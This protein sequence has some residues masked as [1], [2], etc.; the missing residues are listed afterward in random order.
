MVLHVSKWITKDL[1]IE[2]H[3]WLHVWLHSSLHHITWQGSGA[4]AAAACCGLSVLTAR[5]THKCAARV[6]LLDNGSGDRPQG[7]LTFCPLP[8]AGRILS[9][10]S[11]TPRYG[12]YEQCESPHLIY[13]ATSQNDF[14]LPADSIPQTASEQTTNPDFSP[15]MPYF[16]PN[17][18]FCFKVKGLGFRF[19]FIRV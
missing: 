7:L 11:L 9:C 14:W 5:R 17:L 2:L 10:P 8:Q 3:A 12:Q 18:L 15:K 19:F 6:R 13:R 16:Y 4:A 1:N